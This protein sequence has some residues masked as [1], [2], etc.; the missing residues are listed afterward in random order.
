MMKSLKLSEIGV[1]DILF[2]YKRTVILIIHSFLYPYE[3]EEVHITCSCTEISKKNGSKCFHKIF[4]IWKDDID[5]VIKCK[6]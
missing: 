1:G 3:E 5:E 4:T 6:M 2:V